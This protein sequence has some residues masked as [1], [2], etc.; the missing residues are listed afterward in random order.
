[1]RMTR[2]LSLAV[3][4][5]LVWCVAS[6][7]PDPVD[8]TVDLDHLEV[9]RGDGQ[10]GMVGTLL[11]DSIVAKAV[12]TEG[13]ESARPLFFRIASGNGKVTHGGATASGDGASVSSSFQGETAVAWTLGPVAGA[14]TLE[15][16]SLRNNGDTARIVVHATATPAAATAT[17]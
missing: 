10:Q 7:G 9:L 4:A 8:V 15:V 11:P 16:F 3:A 1:M 14:Q 13:L 6:C 5:M 2:T 17:R 12:S